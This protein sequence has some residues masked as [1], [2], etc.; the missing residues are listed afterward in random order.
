MDIFTLE[1]FLHLSETLHY[2][3]TSKAKHISPSAL[4]RQIQRLEEQVGQV[5]FERDNRKVLLTP[6]GEAFREYAR[7]ILSTWE[8]ARE[9]FQGE[10]RELQG[11]L[12]IYSSVTGCYGV[13]PDLLERF[14]EAY[15]RVH[16]HLETGDHALALDKVLSG[17][18]DLAVAALPDT[19]PSSL[20]FKHVTDSPLLFIAPE[21]PWAGEELLNQ[22]PIPWGEI[23]L[24]LPEKDLARRRVEGWF[25]EKGILPRIY[26]EAAGNEAILAMVNLGC[27]VGV[28]PELVIEKRPLRSR[29]KIIPVSP[30][31]ESYHIGLVVHKRK[32][33]AP[34][35]D[36]FLA[37]S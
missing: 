14:R 19:L 1:L 35:V 6:S 29:V 25:K 7:T 26:A 32:A 30:P 13:L 9:A 34:L 37:L 3:R 33:A 11:E 24:I 8:E 5:L 18:H 21:I 20:R 10:G 36:A 15:P 12:K 28:V 27:G 31:L 4:S 23:P 22:E 17:E 16:I 2:G